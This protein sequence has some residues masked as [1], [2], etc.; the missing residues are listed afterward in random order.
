M[1]G[2]AY[3][4]RASGVQQLFTQLHTDYTFAYSSHPNCVLTAI[5]K[6]LCKR[7]GAINKEVCPR[8]RVQAAACSPGGTGLQRARGTVTDFCDRTVTDAD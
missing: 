1:F 3:E 4:R 7:Q 8:D 6:N 2:I 5:T